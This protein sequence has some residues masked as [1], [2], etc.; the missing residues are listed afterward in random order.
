MP[1]PW[2]KGTNCGRSN[3]RMFQFQHY[4][5]SRGCEPVEN[6]STSVIINLIYI[7]SRVFLNASVCTVLYCVHTRGRAPVHSVN[8]IIKC[9]I[10]KQIKTN[11]LHI[12]HG[13]VLQQLS[14]LETLWTVPP[15]DIQCAAVLVSFIDNVTA[16]HVHFYSLESE[17][18][19][20]DI[21]ADLDSTRILW[22]PE[23]GPM[24][25]SWWLL[26]PSPHAS[27]HRHPNTDGDR[28]ELH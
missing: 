3:V 18:F 11:H 4:M 28:L 14:Q 7:L 21:L 13:L 16:R 27:S 25:L 12:M 8:N 15:A 24:K 20:T 22:Q 1:G 9:Y 5:E 19:E 6:F 26:I 17:D 10:H 2:Q 23:R